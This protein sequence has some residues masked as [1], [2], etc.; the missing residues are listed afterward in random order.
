[1]T[2]RQE[3]V[4]FSDYR[5][6]WRRWRIVLWLFGTAFATLAA[7]IPATEMFSPLLPID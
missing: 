6:R 1:M 3:R 2:R 5:E 7:H 4:L